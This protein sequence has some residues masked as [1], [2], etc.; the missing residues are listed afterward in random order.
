MKLSFASKSEIGPVRQLNADTVLSEER[1]G[2]CVLADGMGSRP[3][4]VSASQ[5]VVEELRAHA[6][7]SLPDTAGS[8][9]QTLKTQSGITS[10]ILKS[11]VQRANARLYEENQTDPERAG[12]PVGSTIASLLWPEHDYEYLSYCH[13]GDSRIY[14]YRDGKLNLLT[15]DHTSFEAWKMAGSEGE[16]PSKN[17]LNRAVG[18]Q[19]SIEVDVAGIK[20]RVNDVFIL[21]SDGISG[22]LDDDAILNV[23]DGHIPDC[24]TA[25]CE[26]LITAATDAGSKDNL[27]V[28]VAWIR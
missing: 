18:I 1:L 7:E 23:M 3:E 20:P 26:A 21:C 24:G 16:C 27:S 12:N 22:T 4:A 10:A 5:T 19:S 15:R 6:E 2:L 25:L 28:I 11:G 17:I 8:P 13:A 14:L 9:G